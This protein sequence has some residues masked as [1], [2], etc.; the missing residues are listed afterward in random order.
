MPDA[1]GERG[2]YAV[3]YALLMVVLIGIGAFVVDISMMRESRA[4]NRSAADA[5]VVAAAS[6]LNQLDP[7]ASLPRVACET[8]WDYLMASIPGLESGKASCSAFPDKA[9]GPPACTAAT[10]PIVAS[11][12]PGDGKWTVRI[13]W[14]VPDGSPLLDSPDVYGSQP[15][16]TLNVPFDGSDIDACSRMAVEVVQK[17]GILLG[18]AMGFGGTVDTRAASVARSTVAGETSEVIAALNI[19]EQ[20]DCGALKTQGQGFIV[21][22]GIADSA[23]I[24]AVE[25]SGTGNCGGNDTH[26]IQASSN[27]NNE[28]S[29]LGPNGVGDGIIQTYA[30]NPVPTGNPGVASYDNDRITPDP[31]RLEARYGAKPVTDLFACAGPDC[32][33]GGGPYVSN[34]VGS[35]GSGTPSPYA[36]AETPYNTAPFKELPGPD[37][38]EFR[39]RYTGSTPA[40]V[41]VP[42]GN[43]YVNCPGTGTNDGLIV[44]YPVI[45]EGGTVVVEGKVTVR[46][47]TGCLAFNVPTATACPTINGAVT[48]VTTS[49]GPDKDALLFIRNGPLEKG[50]QGALFMPRTFTYLANGYTN[51]GGGS[52][53]LLWTTPQAQDCDL[54]SVTDPAGCKV[55]RFN[56][57]VLWSESSQDHLMKGQ[58]GLAI[59]GVLFTPNA[60]TDFDGQG[61]QTQTDAQFWTK[62]LHMSGQGTLRM[63]SDP[64]ASVARPLLGVSLIR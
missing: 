29:V 34:L 13:T 16:Q 24:V 4:T 8:A 9:I 53:P 51:L 44:D 6:R 49:P 31:T 18:A 55:E 50:S 60:L 61:L 28:I 26:T 7:N 35:L 15:T 47:N 64:D 56:R 42:E 11:A 20:N 21:V 10:V 38:P 63:R 12:S 23:G 25:S 17:N 37:V 5:A 39:C 57:L 33:T 14:P 32:A 1:S 43:W 40:Y 54:P 36:G 52:G 45:F 30:L 19:L 48:P 2:A 59:R 3:L 22:E 41:S 58:T 46:S 27:V 62:K